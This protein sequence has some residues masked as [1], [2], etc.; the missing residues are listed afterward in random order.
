M[1][2]IAPT[3]PIDVIPVAADTPKLLESDDADLAIGFMPPLEAG[4]FEQTLFTESFVC[5]ARSD[6]PR[7]G[8]TLTMK[9][10]KD[11]SY[12]EIVTSGTGHWIVEK[13]LEEN[14]IRPHVTLK[15]PNFLG[16]PAIVASSD[17]RRAW[18]PQVPDQQAGRALSGSDVW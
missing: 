10:V 8:K 6:H 12:L 13:V 2:E 1:N 14:K 9:S 7:I 15:V 18:R 4:Y 17:H 5:A 16:I 3:M 11:E